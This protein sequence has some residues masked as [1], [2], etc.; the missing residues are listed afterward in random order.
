MKTDL[1]SFDSSFAEVSLHLNVDLYIANIA[2]D[3]RTKKSPTV[4]LSKSCNIEVTVTR[5]SKEQ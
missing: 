2:E 4:L 1:Y 5:K 3:T